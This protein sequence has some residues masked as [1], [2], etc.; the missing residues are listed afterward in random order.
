M[1]KLLL[2]TSLLLGSIF[3]SKGQT[4]PTFPGGEQVMNKFISNNLKYPAEAKENG[5]EGIVEVGF[6]VMTDGKLQEIKVLKLVDPDLE[7][8][9]VRIVGIMP[10]WIPAQKDGTPI[11]AP[12]KIEIPFILED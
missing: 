3:I 7:K 4:A 10:R 8:E 2:V 11:E 5:V 12:Y 9:A 1:K 6:L